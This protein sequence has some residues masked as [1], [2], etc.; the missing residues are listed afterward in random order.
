MGFGFESFKE[1]GV[2]LF[3]ILDLIFALM[4]VQ[5]EG[6]AKLSFLIEHGSSVVQS[7]TAYRAQHGGICPSCKVC[8]VGW[9][10]S[11]KPG[12]VNLVR[13]CIEC[14]DTLVHGIII[15]LLEQIAVSVYSLPIA[16]VETLTRL[17]SSCSQVVSCKVFTTTCGLY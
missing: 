13:R 2:D 10:S 14:F 4:A 5:V 8:I 1:F 11:I 16:T 12:N 9:Y 17:S 15:F 7:R 6:F 3:S